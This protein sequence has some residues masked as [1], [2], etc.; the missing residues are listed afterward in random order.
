MNYI[1]AQ[2]LFWTGL[3]IRLI[4]IISIEP[5]YAVFYYVPFMETAGFTLTPWSAWLMSGGSIEAFPYG[6][7]MW[8]ALLPAASILTFLD[9]PVVYGYLATLLIA[10]FCLL[11]TLRISMPKRPKLLLAAYWCSPVVMLATYGMG[12]NDI[13]PALLLMASVHLLK[14]NRIRWAGVVLAA[15]LSSK[16][17]M[18]VAA[19]LILIYLLNN[20]ALRSSIRPFM[21]SVIMAS[22]VF[23][24]PFIASQDAAKMLFGNPELMKVL[25]I[26]IEIGARLQV[27]VVP[28]SYLLILYAAWR[29]K[30]LNYDL[31]VAI[32]ALALLFM[33]LTTTGSP[34]WFIWALPFLVIY[35]SNGNR[36]TAFVVAVFALLF[37]VELIL[38]APPSASTAVT[39]HAIHDLI[40]NAGLVEYLNASVIH[41]TVRT[42]LVA[43][44]II[45][46]FRVWRD[47]IR[48]NNFFRISR[49]PFL[50]GIAGDSGSGKDTYADSIV[51]LFGTHSAGCVHGD[52]YHLWDRGRPVWQAITHLNPMA[53]DIDRLAQDVLTLKRGLAIR[54]RHYNHTTGMISKPRTVKSNDL[55][56]VSGLHSLNSSLLRESFNLSVYLDMD[57]QLRKHLKIK[58]DMHQRGYSHDQVVKAINRRQADAKKFIKPQK[59]HADLILSVRAADENFNFETYTGD[60]PRL[61]LGIETRSSDKMT[62]LHRALVGFCGLQVDIELDGV[63]GR[64]EMLIEGEVLSEDIAEVVEMIC[65][66]LKE[67]LDRP[68][69]YHGGALGLMQLVTL[70]HIDTAMRLKRFA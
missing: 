31:L 43:I 47:A 17:S 53:N 40:F 41:S 52:D 27:Y 56:I 30:R 46:G 10:D 23:F 36:I 70:C 35:Q 55:I 64:V 67:F 12:L 4:L 9:L 51:D 62:A 24:L 18:I 19:P 61:A 37:T 28:L 2:S 63:N 54:S 21:A 34:A 57:E 14:T 42:A 22:T 20:N 16:I 44:G 32:L 26:A 60:T 13:I 68:A 3:A 25:S 69:K 1:G 6:Y 29:T 33:V 39:T 58:R 48:E 8:L 45:L 66:E 65:P 59:Q 49:S 11:I 5:V 50:I 7:V 38:K 15:A